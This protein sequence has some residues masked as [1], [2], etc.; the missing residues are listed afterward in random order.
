[1]SQTKIIRSLGIY[2]RGLFYALTIVLGLQAAFSELDTG[3][4]ENFNNFVIL[5]SIVFILELYTSW[6]FRKQLFAQT[7]IPGSD[8]FSDVIHIIHHI[9]VPIFLYIGIVGFGY[10]NHQMHLRTGLLLFTLFILTVM[11]ANIRA[12]Y[13]NQK[14]L[15]I[16]TNFIYDIA[17][18]LIF[19]TLSNTLI[20]YLT[21][22]NTLNWTPLILA[23]IEL[24]LITLMIMR[25]R[26]YELL[27]FISSLAASLFM[28]AVVTILWQINV[29]N[30]L[31]ISL[32]AL[33]CYYLSMASI[34]HLMERTLSREIVL[35]YIL[36]LILS[37]TL[38]YGLA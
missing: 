9:V 30:P 28:M 31:Q 5:I 4:L 3:R 27:G 22:N 18:I 6:L 14:K 37:F 15:E 26:K 25:Y 23:M 33:V 24:A 1:M 13:E 17:K 16:R 34:H 35:E 29:F 11:F 12:F 7:E 32:Y 36:I 8:R 20:N 2:G 10:F 38:L 21:Q 19:F